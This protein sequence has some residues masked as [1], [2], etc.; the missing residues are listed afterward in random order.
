MG[1]GVDRQ[2]FHTEFFCGWDELMHKLIVFLGHSKQYIAEFKYSFLYC[3]KRQCF[4]FFF[5]LIKHHDYKVVHIDF[6]S[7]IVHHPSSMNLSTTKVPVSPSFSLSFLSFLGTVIPTIV[8]EGVVCIL[9]CLHPTLCY[10]PKWSVPIQIVILIP[11][12]S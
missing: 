10:W 11:S 2:I 4:I 12:L 6:Q 1:K 9:Y 5:Y 3:Y 8:N 7:Y